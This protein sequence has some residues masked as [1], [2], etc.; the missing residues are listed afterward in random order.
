VKVT[1]EREAPDAP[2]PPPPSSGGGSKV[3]AIIAFG[4]GVAGTG[5]GAVFG[6]LAFQQTSETKDRC[7]GNVCPDNPLVVSARDKAIQYGNISTVGFIAGGVGV[8]TGIVLL[9]VSSGSDDPAPA[10]TSGRVLPWIGPGQAGV[11]GTF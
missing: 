1:L 2:P 9:L 6:I 3:P 7:D 5:V 8:A 10:E 11:V 4:V